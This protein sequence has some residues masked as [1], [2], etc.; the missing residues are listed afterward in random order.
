LEEALKFE[1]PAPDATE[2]HGWNVYAMNGNDTRDALPFSGSFADAD[3]K[4][5]ISDSI[6]TF[7]EKK[8]QRISYHSADR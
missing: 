7:D 6:L 4:I 5:V 8:V 3:S 1:V 2:D